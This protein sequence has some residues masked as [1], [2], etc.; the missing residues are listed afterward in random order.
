MPET[1]ASFLLWKMF[2]VSH[3]RIDSLYCNRHRNTIDACSFTR[4]K[5]LGFVWFLTLSSTQGK[6]DLFPFDSPSNNSYNNN[7]DLKLA[8][9]LTRNFP[10]LF[11]FPFFRTLFFPPLLFMQTVLVSGSLWFQEI[12]HC[13]RTEQLYIYVHTMTMNSHWLYLHGAHSNSYI[14]YKKK[15]IYIGVWQVSKTTSY[16]QLENK[17]FHY[18]ISSIHFV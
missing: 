16:E 1:R 10:L 15:D 14:R 6:F 5:Q 12:L 3:L 7:F 18:T 8:S 13:H 2:H 4:F 17:A 9:V 11:L